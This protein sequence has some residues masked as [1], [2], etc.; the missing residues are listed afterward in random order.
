LTPSQQSLLILLWNSN[1]LARHREELDTL[2]H[3]RRIDVVLV[4][5]T[6][7]TE[8]SR[9]YIKD[10]TVY[11]TD[12]PDNSA[13]GGSAII[14]K[15]S[16]SHFLY[17]SVSTNFLQS[18]T[19]CLQ[20][21]SS[22]IVL[23][24]S[25]WPPNKPISQSQFL[26]YF[27]SL[28]PNF[29]AGGDYN[30]KHPQWGCRVGNPRGSTLLSSLSSTHY[31]ILS[32]PEPT[33]WPTSLSKLP[34]ILDIFITT[35]L[36]PSKYS[37]ET[38]YDLSSDHSPVLL[39][40]HEYPLPKTPSPFLVRGPVN[41]DAFRDELDKNI[42]LNISLKTKD[43]LDDAVNKLTCTIHTAI[44]NNMT[45][46]RTP[47]SK[48]F[49]LPHQIREYISKKRRARKKWQLTRLPSHK[50]ELN[51]LTYVLKTAL[52]TYRQDIETYKLSQLTTTNKSL[53]TKTKQILKHKTASFPIALEDGG[54]AKT[55]QQ[56]ADILSQHLSR[57][58]SLSN[59][60]LT[61][62]MNDIL[63]SPLPLTL[64]PKAFNPSDVTY[65]IRQLKR[66]KAP[67]YDLITAEILS[68]L[69]RKSIVFLTYLFNAVLRTTH[70]PIPWKFAIV[71]MI[72][73][74]NKP[75]HLPSSYRPISLLPILGKILE[76]LLLRRLYPLL[77]EQKVIPD[78]QFGFRTNHSTIQQCHRM[79]DCIAKALEEKQ[80]CAGAFLDASQA[81]DRVWH[82]GLLFKLKPL[83]P[84]TYFLIL[85]SFLSDRY[86][87][88]SYGSSVSRIFPTLSGVP[89]G[90]I[91]APLLFNVYTADIPSHP[92]TVLH[93]FADDTAILSTDTSCNMASSNLQ[94]H[95]NSIH[96]WITKWHLK[97]N[98]DKS[99]SITFTLRKDNC[100]ILFLDGR[101]IP[102]ADVV[103]YLG[104]YIDKKLTWNPH[105]R[106]KR[107]T[108]KQ[109]FHQLYRLIGRTSPLTTQNKLTI[110]KALLRPIW[111]YGL[112]L[113]GSTK[114]SNSHRIQSIQSKVLRCIVNAPYYVTNLTLHTDLKI[115]FVL[116]LARSRYHSFNAKLPSHP[117]P[118]AS[119][120]ASQNIPV[121]RLKRKW[122]RDLLT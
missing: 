31:H 13:H 7:F 85:Q 38:L 5:E 9:F 25:Y 60:P 36:P 98:V 106:L 58:F 89:Q 75:P 120:L 26:S 74:P 112:E 62:E 24:S 71:K 108:F 44:Y 83:L 80:Y 79:I 87:Q 117:N 45:E 16:I 41:W 6:H 82:R 43:E 70:F 90:S 95:L 19:L 37:I 114:P 91:L 68:H 42:S 32:P 88:I 105:T 73:K 113:W 28:G 51:R 56:K 29:I 4:T 94:T 23:S 93:T 30:A 61:D 15:N 96:D 109:R 59:H 18:T 76:K 49:S 47:S 122:P 12:H 8:K 92:Q 64:P 65:C 84:S 10:Y 22:A 67:G 81:F 103:K 40:L 52:R 35:P 100:P 33:Y 116:D 57:I 102:Q 48:T 2:I 27:Q 72:P 3:D 11:R 77:Y 63:T 104:L 101:P 39:T 111:T 17:P 55:D 21:V 110:Y 14:I 54:W 86:S 46:N 50:R 107:L 115:P 1:G 97:V 20:F 66:R 53:W 118:L 69:S 99:V 119:S 121:R 34:D 78:H